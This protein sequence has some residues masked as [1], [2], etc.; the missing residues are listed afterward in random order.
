MASLLW[1]FAIISGNAKE[2]PILWSQLNSK[3]E[4]FSKDAPHLL[5]ATK[6]ETISTIRIAKSLFQLNEK[7]GG[8]T[9]RFLDDYQSFF[10]AI[11]Q[12]VKNEKIFKQV[13]AE[14]DF[15]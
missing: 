8:K 1:A 13:M 15:G 12:A 9:T 10:E 7:D 3:I 5:F 11:T 4:K 14:Q 2:F 6:A